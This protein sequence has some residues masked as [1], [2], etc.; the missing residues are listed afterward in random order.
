MCFYI[1]WSQKVIG[2]IVQLVR[3]HEWMA[4]HPKELKIFEGKWI[5]ILENNVIATGNS[6]LEVWNMVKEKY[7]DNLPLITYVLRPEETQMIANVSL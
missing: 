4:K 7:P 5:A 1:C 2:D 3:E 6:Y